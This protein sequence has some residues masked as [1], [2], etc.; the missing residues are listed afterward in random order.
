MLAI[1]GLAKVEQHSM[2]RIALRVLIP[3]FQGL[4]AKKTSTNGS[5][6]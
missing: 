1:D 3:M 6:L 4:A 5:R 2:A